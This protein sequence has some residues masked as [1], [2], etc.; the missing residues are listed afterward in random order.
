LFSASEGLE[1]AAG[2]FLDQ[3]RP[4]EAAG[5]LYQMHSLKIAYDVKL[6]LR[7]M[8]ASAASSLQYGHIERH[9]ILTLIKSMQENPEVKEDERLALEWAWLPLLDR[10]EGAAPVTMDRKLACD[11]DFYHEMITK[12]FRS[13]HDNA[14]K[15]SASTGPPYVCEPKSNATSPFSIM[16][17][18]P[19][20]RLAKQYS[21]DHKPSPSEPPY[22]QSFPNATVNGPPPAHAWA[23]APGLVCRPGCAL[24]GRVAEGRLRRV[25]LVT[26]PPV[27]NVEGRCGKGF[28]GGPGVGERG[29]VWRNWFRRSWRASDRGDGRL[30]REPAE[31]AGVAPGPPT[32]GLCPGGRDDRSAT[33]RRGGC[34]G[35]LAGLAN[36]WALLVL[37]PRPM[38]TVFR[39]PWGDEEELL[40][41]WADERRDG[42][43]SRPA[44]P[45]WGNGWPFGPTR[46]ARG[47]WSGPGG[48][49]FCRR[50]LCSPLLSG[51]PAGNAVTD[52]CLLT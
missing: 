2:K 45:G 39:K 8:H 11:P 32:P 30:S 7:V 19:I 36:R 9:H 41:R 48:L 25:G 44:G 28:R 33:G 15:M 52:F 43:V 10:E 29:V 20:Q 12:A 24:A 46:W 40:A 42:D 50:R 17:Y 35:L 3:N 37:F 13:T 51:T 49:V 1:F 26:A 4:L 23:L 16:S 47:V 21:S 27:R 34:P 18:D 22:N 6:C 5:C 14:H 38:T 31:R